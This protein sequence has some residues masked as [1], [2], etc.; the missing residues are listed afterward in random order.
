MGLLLY[1]VIVAFRKG[2]GRQDYQ[3]EIS[4]AEESALIFGVGIAK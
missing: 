4:S 1:L 3:S 2:E